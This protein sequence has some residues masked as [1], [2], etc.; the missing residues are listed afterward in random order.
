MKSNILWES[1][2]GAIRSFS[3]MDDE[4]LANVLLH[5]THYQTR[6]NYG[7]YI[8]IMAEI[9]KRK[10]TKKFLSGATYPWRNKRTGVWY[11]WDF[12]KNFIV[13]VSGK[14]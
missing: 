10:L 1:V 11:I 13:E 3:A 6:Y 7:I 5:V 4:H 12:K 8:N 9:E 2:D 14:V